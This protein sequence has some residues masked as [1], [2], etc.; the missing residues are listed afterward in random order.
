MRL[1]GQIDGTENGAPRDG[2][3]ENV[4]GNTYKPEGL[5]GIRNKNECY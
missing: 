2:G 1:G 3:H 5:A 4:Q